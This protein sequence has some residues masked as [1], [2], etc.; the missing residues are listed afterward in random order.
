MDSKLGSPPVDFL[1]RQPSPDHESVLIALPDQFPE[2][3]R[4]PGQ[5]LLT[6]CNRQ[7]TDCL[8][9]SFALQG[10]VVL[11]CGDAAS[12]ARV[13]TFANDLLARM[14]DDNQTFRLRVDGTAALSMALVTELTTTLGRPQSVVMQGSC[15]ELYGDH[16]YI[17]TQAPLGWKWPKKLPYRAYG[18][19][20]EALLSLAP[21][22]PE[23]VGYRNRQPSDSK[24]APHGN[25]APSD[26]WQTVHRRKRKVVKAQ[27]CRDF[28]RGTCSRGDSCIFRHVKEACRDAAR[29]RCNRRACK[30]EHV[31]EPAASGVPTPPPA[32]LGARL[33]VAASSIS[34]V[35]SHGGSSN[36][37]DAEAQPAPLDSPV[38]N[39]ADAVCG[40]RESAASASSPTG[41][42]PDRSPAPSAASSP[43]SAHLGRQR[44]RRGVSSD[45]DLD[46][47]LDDNLSASPADSPR[48][49]RTRARSCP[50]SLPTDEMPAPGSPRSAW[51]KPLA[52]WGPSAAPTSVLGVKRPLARSPPQPTAA[53]LATSPAARE[54]LQQHAVPR[55]GAGLQAL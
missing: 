13:R 50:T 39:F 21:N 15:S 24:S 33:G 36:G 14:T 55:V 18:L 41:T 1:N 40:G 29:G 46:E 54:P 10:I 47:D 6:A 19:E 37:G 49:S 23:H 16:A 35:P 42:G 52:N 22:S 51:L 32:A 12:A 34:H 27:P 38:S 4:N 2:R 44:R 17:I 11:I 43:K 25:A 26:E 53:S 28:M 30:F 45:E 3:I 48:P 8:L 5:F 20:L 31:L 7:F 9:H